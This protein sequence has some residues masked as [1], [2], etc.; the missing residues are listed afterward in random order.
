M[1]ALEALT[2]PGVEAGTWQVRNRFSKASCALADRHYSRQAIGSP[3][4]GGP[5]R[6]LILVSPC[7]R[8][9]WIS[10]LHMPGTTAPRALADGLDAFRCSLFRNEGAGLSSD[11][12]RAAVEITERLW[13]EPPADGW[14]TYV[15]PGKITSPS[16]EVV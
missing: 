5:G 15:E 16:D 7:E 9:T 4:V 14:A 12:I 8:A 11:L 3:Q 2:I 10:K 1:S 13:G 6:V